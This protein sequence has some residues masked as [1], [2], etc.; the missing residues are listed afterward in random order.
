M[1]IRV[2]RSSNENC[3]YNEMVGEMFH[4]FMI[5][6]SPFFFI[7][8]MLHFYPEDVEAI[9]GGADGSFGSLQTIGIA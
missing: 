7:S 3:W 9:K 5:T 4:V 2:V 6:G 8:L 1:K